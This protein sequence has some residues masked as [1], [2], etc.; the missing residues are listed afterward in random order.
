MEVEHP[1]N[2]TSADGANVTERKKAPRIS[3]EPLNDF[4]LILH[5][6]SVDMGQPATTF[7]PLEHILSFAVKIKKFILL[8]VPGFQVDDKMTYNNLNE[9]KL[10]IV[11]DKTI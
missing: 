6:Q 9:K 4:F 5:F 3:C 7:T 11:D 10:M 8:H 2:L 1:E